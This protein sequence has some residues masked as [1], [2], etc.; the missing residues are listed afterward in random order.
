MQAPAHTANPDW[1]W[2][3]PP[4]PPVTPDPLEPP[5]LA[6]VPPLPPEPV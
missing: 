6:T 5:A 3:E 4:T 2:L 1:H